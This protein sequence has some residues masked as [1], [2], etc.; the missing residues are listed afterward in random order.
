MVELGGGGRGGGSVAD[1]SAEHLG[2]VFHP[3]DACF[4]RRCTSCSSSAVMYRQSAAR[5]G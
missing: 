2:F 5:W 3:T 4:L 1:R